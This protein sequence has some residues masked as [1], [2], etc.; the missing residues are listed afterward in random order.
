ME[1]EQT[2]LASLFETILLPKETK[3]EP[4][5]KKIEEPII[6]KDVSF[7]EKGLCMFF[8]KKPTEIEESLLQ[9]ILAAIKV[10]NDKTQRIHTGEKDFDLSIKECT[11]THMIVW[12]LSLE[13]TNKYTPTNL[14]N[15]KI[16]F[17]DSLSQLNEDVEL[18]K[19]LWN[20]LKDFNS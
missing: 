13:N 6:N 3:D 2:A 20:A 5:K 18:K 15:I 11:K 9:K 19:Q 1:I 17:S 7:K 8:E 4:A 12:G 16:L 10:T 14:E